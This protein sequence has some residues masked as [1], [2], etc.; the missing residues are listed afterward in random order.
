MSVP[1]SVAMRRSGLDAG[2]L[3]ISNVT[4]RSMPE[5]MSRV[6]GSRVAAITL[7]NTILVAGHMYDDVVSGKQPELL[8]HE[9]VHVGQWRREGSVGFLL[10]YVSDYV[11]NRMIGLSHRVAYRAIGF[12]A[13]AYDATEQQDQEWT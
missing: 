2:S 6:L 7:G 3:D 9:L 12:E 10:A 5:W 1:A 13:A 11:G 4:I 8:R